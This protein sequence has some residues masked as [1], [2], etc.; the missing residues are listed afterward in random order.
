MG[1][2]I[3]NEDRLYVKTL[4]LMGIGVRQICERLGERFNLGK[5]M[6]RMTMYHHFRKEIGNKKRGRKMGKEK[7]SVKI[8]NNII[9]EM[10]RMMEEIKARRRT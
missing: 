5:P 2:K 6:S 1:L 10:N 3:S 4:S 8:K 7:L 9:E